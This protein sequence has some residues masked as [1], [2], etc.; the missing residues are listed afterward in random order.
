M[1][2]PGQPM[3]GASPTWQSGLVAWLFVDLVLVL[4][5]IQL[6][7]GSA[8]PAAEVIAPTVAAAPT[9]T[10]ATTAPATAAPPA[11]D[12]QTWQ[13]TLDPGFD[14]AAVLQNDPAERARVID[15]IRQ[16]TAGIAGRRA[17]VVLLFGTAYSGS[18]R[19]D[20]GRGSAFA[21]AI[22]PMLVEAA[23]DL[24]PPGEGGY[25]TYHDLNRPDGALKIELFLFR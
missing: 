4:F 6:G 8:A 5:L 10:A 18:G 23:P 21:R 17:G 7:S 13:V 2:R 9:S 25:R 1:I 16:E 3:S 20:S 19:A 12:E 14:V 22:V 24:F 15:R 11:L